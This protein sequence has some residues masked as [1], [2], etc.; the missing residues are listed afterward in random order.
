MTKK[1]KGKGVLRLKGAERFCKN[2]R[3]ALPFKADSNATGDSIQYFKQIHARPINHLVPYPAV[4]IQCNLATSV[5]E[6]IVG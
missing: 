6:K 1:K 3:A 2:Y 5:D 4:S